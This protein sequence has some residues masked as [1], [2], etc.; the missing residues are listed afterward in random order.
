M[1]MDT[2]QEWLSWMQQIAG[3]VVRA[4]ARGTL[5]EAFP[6][7]FHYERARYFAPLEAFARTLCGIAPWLQAQG[8]SPEEEAQRAQ[9]AEW[10]REG[11]DRGTDLPSPSGFYFG[12]EH[13]GQSLVDAAFLCHALLRA[14]EALASPLAPAVR[15]R[16]AECLRMTRE[17]VPPQNNWIL[18]AAMVEAGLRLLGDPDV[19]T[20]IVEY[21][22]S[23]H[24][25]W[26]QGDGVYGDGPAFHWDYYN[27]FVIQPM[28]VDISR[29]FADVPE[30]SRHGEI[31]AA[32]ARRYAE[33]QERMIA[34]D[35]TYPILGRSI[36]YRFGA[37]QMLSQ[38]ALQEMLPPAVSPAQVRCALTAV[39]RRTLLAPNTFDENGFLHP[40][41]YGNQPALAESYINRASLYLCCAVFLPLGLPPRHAFWRAPDAAWTSVRVWSGEDM[42]ADHAMDH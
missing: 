6:L 25:E 33:I 39:L 40:G 16:L 28:L 20:D 34:P 9:W 41:V 7:S 29:L 21:G 31:I 4:A 3:P 2:R 36:L 27:S 17:I 8:L 5:R 38:A 18:F 24:M 26:Y 14:P 10:A 15:A 22:I 11:I 35:G 32:R 12:K 13:G 37:F 42:P 19:R 23:R 30:V 1:A